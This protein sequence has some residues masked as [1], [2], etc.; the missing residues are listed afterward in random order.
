MTKVIKNS[1]LQLF[2]NPKFGDIRV[3]DIEGKPYFVAS[4]VAKCLG[5][6]KPNNA[7]SSHCKHATLIQGITDSIGR[8][9]SMNVIPQGDIYR[10][11]AK[12]ELPGAEEFESWIFDEVLV[13]V[14][15][16]GAYMTPDT[17]ENVIADPEFGIQ[18]LTALKNEREK[19][20]QLEGDL[21]K[22]DE[23]IHIQ[24][25]AINE[26]TPKAEYT[27]KVLAS[28]DTFTATQIA[29]EFGWGAV[30]LNNKL[31]ELRVQY[32][33]GGQWLLYAKYQNKGY[34]KSHTYTEDLAGETR[35]WHSTVWTE[36]G[37]QFIHELL[38]Q[39]DL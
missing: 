31:K 5:Y 17:L 35:T 19:S 10:L 14:A 13:S 30:T 6:V 32:K 36:K 18:L 34:T 4:D 28:K 3:V 20:R 22:K 39:K 7:V 16:H 9:Q 23:L 33:H 26:L 25:S 38:N 1:E 2:S 11:A 21:Y 37:R 29:K 27:D 24:H 15:N 12:S 8:E